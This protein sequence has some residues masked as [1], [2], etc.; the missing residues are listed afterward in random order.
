MA[1]AALRFNKIQIFSFREE[2]YSSVWS[3]HKS[4]S[5]F[6]QKRTFIKLLKLLVFMC[7]K[8]KITKNS[9]REG[10]NSN[11]ILPTKASHQCQTQPRDSTSWD[12]NTMSCKFYQFTMHMIP[13]LVKSINL[14]FSKFNTNN[15][16]SMTESFSI[17]FL[18][19][20]LRSVGSMSKSKYLQIF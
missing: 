4:I 3:Y 18:I 11:Q 2:K 19:N 20:I 7:N 10:S 14:L 16:I 8:S 17:K 1:K 9:S 12:S 6:W 5:I 13:V 15:I